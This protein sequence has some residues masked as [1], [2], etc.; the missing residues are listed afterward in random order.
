MILVRV[1]MQPIPW[2]QGQ[3]SLLDDDYSEPDTTDDGLERMTA[4]KEEISSKTSGFLQ[5]K[6]QKLLMDQMCCVKDKNTS[7][8]ISSS[9]NTMP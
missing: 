7:V 3:E 4:I 6:Q 2:G 5:Y 9:K 1:K 8:L